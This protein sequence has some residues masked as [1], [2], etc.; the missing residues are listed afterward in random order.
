MSGKS[1]K[2]IITLP[3]YQGKNITLDEFKQYILDLLENHIARHYFDSKA[4]NGTISALLP[5]IQTG[6][7]KIM[8]LTNPECEFAFIQ[9][10]IVKHDK[11][12]K[13]AK[14]LWDTADSY[15]TNSEYKRKVSD[16]CKGHRGKNPL[17][18]IA[19]SLIK[20]VPKDENISCLRT[21]KYWHF[22][23]PIVMH[24]PQSGINWY[25]IIDQ[26]EPLVGGGKLFSTTFRE[27]LDG[28]KAHK[29]K[30]HNSMLWQES[31]LHV[32]DRHLVAEDEDE[33][34]EEKSLFPINP[35][36]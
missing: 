24:L 25:K 10:F 8:E 34:K 35:G 5:Q 7:A 17:V 30:K 27:I 21:D 3:L 4:G 16:F 13:H 18:I 1:K 32:T 14:E 33:E 23:E 9:D 20:L 6:L 15:L 26:N 11:Q 31:I 36:Q 28:F 29:S 2:R 12:R 19:S 22:R